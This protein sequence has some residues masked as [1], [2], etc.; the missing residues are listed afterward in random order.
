MAVA[1]AAPVEVAAGCAIPAATGV[2]P[3]AAGAAGAAGANVAAGPA[4]IAVGTGA[5]LSERGEAAATGAAPAA[6]ELALGAAAA[7]ASTAGVVPA[8][9]SPAPSDPLPCPAPSD[10]AI[11]RTAA[12]ASAPPNE[13]ASAA[14]A[15]S[16][17]AS[18]A[19][20]AFPAPRADRASSI[21]ALPLLPSGRRSTERATVESAAAALSGSVRSASPGRGPEFARSGVG[22][23]AGRFDPVA[24]AVTLG[25]TSYRVVA[26]PSRATEAPAVPR[27]DARLEALASS[28]AA[29]KLCSSD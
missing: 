8:A 15:A 9:A 17:V 22:A 18:V 6:A 3:A 25:R 14:A 21:L 1:L 12:A 26:T 28:N 19:S 2:A 4:A 23:A 7:T 5:T 16:A 10:P 24:A 27:D 11:G 29:P 20:E 13:F